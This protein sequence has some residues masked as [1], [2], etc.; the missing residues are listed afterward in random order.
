MTRT[1]KTITMDAPRDAAIAA[2]DA[3]MA[4]LS[5]L[6]VKK[7]E[8]DAQ[9]E[10]EIDLIRKK[11]HDPVNK[12]AALIMKC[13][14]ELEKLMKIN[15]P[16]LFEIPP[17]SPLFQRGAESVSSRVDLPCGGA[18]IFQQAL[19]VLRKKGMLE[20]LKENGQLKAIK[21]VESV[22]WDK[23]EEFTN[24]TLT[25]LGTERKLHESMEWEL[26]ARDLR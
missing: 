7:A 26:P 9:I 23:V 11:Y 18:L 10:A 25:L 22:N 14:H 5:E 4:L 24:A 21:V 8:T 12:I 17:E 13:E 15:K 2:C 16:L 1:A 3:Q 19:K 6:Y 20:K